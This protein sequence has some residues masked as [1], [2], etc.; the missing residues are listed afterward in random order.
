MCQHIL[1]KAAFAAS[2]V[3]APLA[4]PL[5]A[6]KGDQLIPAE[7]C[8]ESTQQ[9][10]IEQ[11]READRLRN[12]NRYDEA[13][14]AY[15]MARKQAETL[16]ADE[17]PMA[18][19]LNRIGYQ[20]QMLGRLRE[21]ERSYAAALAIVERKSGAPSH[22]AVKLA[23]D[24]SSAYLELDQVARAESLIRRFLRRDNEL[25]SNDRA[26]LLLDL[27]SV[28]AA[29]RNFADA[30]ALYQQA[31]LFFEHDSSRE[32]RERTVIILSNLSTVYMQM[33]RFAEG[34][35]YSDRALA[36]LGTMPDLQPLIVL[37]TMANAAAV[38]AKTGKPPE[39]D[40]LFQ[41]TIAFCEKTF[42]R[43]HYLLGS[44]MSNYAEFLRTTGRHA[45]AKTASKRAKAI[46][47]SFGRENSIGL[48]VDATAFR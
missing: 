2:L 32:S 48:T 41:S 13:E 4:C 44:I 21:A 25:S 1:S 31:L 20:H 38:S 29:K 10:W 43:G 22:N 40:F 27:A 34:R 37:K 16:G 28:L 33:D 45:E 19:T 8:A 15:G 47:N 24:L 11:L 9:A 35:P 7:C 42:G 6:Q 23:L 39:T 5:Q 18:I 17:L 46:M 36:L 12:E 3:A 26:T 14:R 30:E